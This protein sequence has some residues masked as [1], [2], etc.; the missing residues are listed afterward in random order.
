MSDML[1][2]HA[3]WADSLALQYS[4]MRERAGLPDTASGILSG[5][6]KFSV[7]VQFKSQKEVIE[8]SGHCSVYVTEE[9][10]E[11][12]IGVT[13]LPCTVT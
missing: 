7:Q 9:E 4:P 10:N 1:Y 6:A 11:F 13:L 12:E 8:T 5:N 3:T 2:G